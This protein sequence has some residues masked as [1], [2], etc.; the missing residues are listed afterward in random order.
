MS[1]DEADEARH[2]ND[3]NE[4]EARLSVTDTAYVISLDAICSP[5]QEIYSDGNDSDL[6]ITINLETMS[7]L[8]YPGWKVPKSKLV[9]HSGFFR[10]MF[11]HDCRVRTKLPSNSIRM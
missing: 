2:I 6:E 5:V 8:I 4:Q 10:R 1:S 9:K 11:S 7:D 3:V